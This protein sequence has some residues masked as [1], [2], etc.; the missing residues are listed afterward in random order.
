MVRLITKST[1]MQDRKPVTRKRRKPLPWVNHWSKLANKSRHEAIGDVA[2]FLKEKGLLENT[3][4]KWGPTR[5][6]WDVRLVRRQADDTVVWSVKQYVQMRDADRKVRQV[7]SGGGEPHPAD[8]RR[9]LLAN[10]RPHWL[11]EC[12]RAQG[13]AD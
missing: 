10:V 5:L 2:S 6:A 4:G 11:V 1:Q 7:L 9:A 13:K 12:L 3:T 8:M